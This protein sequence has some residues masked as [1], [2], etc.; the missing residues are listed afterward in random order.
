MFIDLT[1]AFD[2]VNRTRLYKVLGRISCPPK[3]LQMIYSFPNRITAWVSFDWDI[4]E[5]FNLRCGMKQAYVMTPILFGIYL[6]FPL[7]CVFLLSDRIAFHARQDRNQISLAHLR[8]KTKTDSVLMCKLLFA[9]DAVFCAQC[10]PK[11]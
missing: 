11:L 9:I 8:S 2:S 4:S 5:P 10:V 6:S 1:K 3:L 7:C